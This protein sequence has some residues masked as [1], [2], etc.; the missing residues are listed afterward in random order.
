MKNFEELPKLVEN[1][2]IV[3]VTI[4]FYYRVNNSIYV[5]EFL[6]ITQFKFDYAL[7]VDEVPTW[8]VRNFDNDNKNMSWID[9]HY[10]IDP[11]Y[12]FLIGRSKML[13]LYRRP[14]VLV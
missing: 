10:T 14:L 13:K 9:L 8:Y 12:H 7:V 4:S 2:R 3:Y 5:G 6:L 11:I 1:N